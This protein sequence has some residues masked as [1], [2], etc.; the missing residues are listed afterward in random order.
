MIVILLD[1]LAGPSHGTDGGF[2][3]KPSIGL[4]NR[5]YID[6]LAEAYRRIGAREVVW[7]GQDGGHR[8]GAFGGVKLPWRFLDTALLRDGLVGRYE[9]VLMADLR[10]WPDGETKRVLKRHRRSP[11]TLTSYARSEQQGHYLEVIAPGPS[12]G[13]CTVSRCYGGGHE[14]TELQRLVALLA[15]PRSLSF[16][17]KSVV[18]ALESHDLDRLRELASQA[19]LRLA[20]TPVLIESVEQYLS[21]SERLLASTGV[22][23]PQARPIAR[24]VWAMPETSVSDDCCL[25]GPVL[26]GRGCTVGRG[27]RVHGPAILGDG[28][29]IAE[30][31]FVGESVLLSD[32][33]LPSGAGAWRSVIGPGAHIEPGQTV[34]HVWMTEEGTH[35]WSPANTPSSLAAVVVPSRRSLFRC[36]LTL[37]SILKRSL[38]ICGAS[39]G[40]ALTLPVY[41]F[42]ALAIK[43][44]SPGPVFFS[45]RRQTR[46]GKTFGCLKFRSMVPNAEAIKHELANQVDG[47]QFHM[48]NDPRLTRVGRFL[49]KT[50]LDEIPQLWNVL[51]G[52]MSLVGPRPSPDAENQYCP[53]WRD[54]RL[55]VRA[56]I[57]GMWQVQRSERS[58]GDFHQWIQYDTQYVREV[59]LHTDLQLLW[60]T[61][62]R[63]LRLA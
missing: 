10:L 52:H 37:Y 46:G 26:L 44:D 61:A 7:A 29:E 22:L 14:Q 40:L 45:H 5:P 21:L 17:W 13:G 60:R 28:V 49:R 27:A 63:L 16:V 11:S 50:N 25:T 8:S 30:K 4:L 3:L 59:S 51:L 23:V 54:T 20:G 56:G 55:S 57:T 19:Q 9:T 34:S 58:D 18:E 41:P 43:L 47:P 33:A 62:M 24:R 32:S 35:H 38:D 1:D 6:R 31:C 48:D 39:L 15:R 12:A 2:D 36:N 53:S 42:I